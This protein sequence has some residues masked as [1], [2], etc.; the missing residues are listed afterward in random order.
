[1]SKSMEINAKVAKGKQKGS[2]REPKGS[3]KGVKIK[4]KTTQGPLRGTLAGKY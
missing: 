2:K 3:Q 4:A 1:M